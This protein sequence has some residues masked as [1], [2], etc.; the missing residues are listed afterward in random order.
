M[1]ADKGIVVKIVVDYY[2]TPGHLHKFRIGFAPRT[3]PK[4]MGVVNYYL[5]RGC[6]KAGTD[7]AGFLKKGVGNEIDI[8]LTPVFVGDTR[9]PIQVIF[10]TFY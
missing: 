6:S 5:E 10:F 1:K 2:N 9:P 8:L 3:V 7:C 4:M